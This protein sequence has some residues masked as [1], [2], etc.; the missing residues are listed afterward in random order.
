LFTGRYANA[1]LPG[2]L[3]SA[4]VYVSTALSDAGISA[5]TAEAMACGVP[6]VVTNTGENDKWIH[7][8]QTGFLVPARASTALADRIIT[9]LCDPALRA[10][11]GDEGR[12]VITTRNNYECEMEKMEA[13]CQ[14][15]LAATPVS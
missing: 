10:K 4:Q 7:D 5:S 3:R 14:D 8:G 11:I 2:M 1:E 12:S 15:L 13:I 9:L 6:V